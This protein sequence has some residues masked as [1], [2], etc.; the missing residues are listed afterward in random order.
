LVALQ[1][2]QI[3]RVVNRVCSVEEI[4]YELMN[5]FIYYKTRTIHLDNIAAIIFH[6][7]YKFALSGLWRVFAVATSLT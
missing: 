5:V 6:G 4:L 2:L 3:E 7:N 1:Y